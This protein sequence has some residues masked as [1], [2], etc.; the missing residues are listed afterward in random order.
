L[1]IG[2]LEDFLELALG[3][4]ELAALLL[5]MGATNRSDGA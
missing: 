3:I 2:G 4:A 1:C 5:Y